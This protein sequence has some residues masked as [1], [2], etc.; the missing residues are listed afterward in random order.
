MSE[1]L[2][3]LL[4]SPFFDAELHS[5]GVQ[6]SIDVV[7]EMLQRG[8][9]VG[10]I[11]AD[12]HR[13][14]GDLQEYADGGQL[15]LYP[16]IDHESTR[17]SHHSNETLYSSARSVIAAFQPDVM[18]IH[19]TQGM[20]SAIFAAVD[21]HVPTVMTVLD[22]GL[23]CF[24]FVL[25]SGGDEICAGPTSPETCRRCINRTIRGPAKH[26]W[27]ILPRP[28]TRKVWPRFV[29]LDQI[30]TAPMLHSLMERARASLD[31]FIV[32]TPKLGDRLHAYGTP[33]ERIH[34]VLYGLRP[35][36]IVRPVKAPSE[37]LRFAY[38]GG[39]DRAKGAHVLTE[40]SEL[41]PDGLP[42]DIRMY[43]GR[44]LADLLHNAPSRSKRYVSYQSPLSD[45]ELAAEHARFDALLLPSIAHE[46]TP[47][48][49]L[50]ALANG[51][52]VIGANRP[53]IDHVIH[54]N[55]NGW[56][57][58]AGDSSAWARVLVHAVKHPAQLRRMAANAY[59]N[60]TLR[61]YLDDVEA[62]EAGVLSRRRDRQVAP[63]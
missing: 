25:Y 60:R 48:A 41:L 47:L 27:P 3:T 43:G 14:L 28:V 57:V 54:S 49:A 36:K 52:P 56:L 55:G 9:T 20:F 39:T 63:L 37:I 35:S 44:E 32:A 59:F 42:L 13:S 46:N 5:G 50:E 23:L 15:Q 1:S 6:L 61:D 8:R 53:G 10:V 34:R 31:A 11:C 7:R 62:V 4:I 58:E 45:D 12:R 21:A 16:L 22:C 26:L 24:N 38:L 29:R 33:Q 18:H 2:R 40:A 17:F 51:T 19:N 30:K